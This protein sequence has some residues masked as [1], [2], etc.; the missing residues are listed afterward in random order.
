MQS[1][2]PK[3][4]TVGAYTPRD[5]PE[6]VSLINTIRTD[7]LSLEQ[8]GE[9]EALVGRP[10][11][12][13]RLVC[14]TGGGIIAIGQLNSSPYV[15]DCFA[16]LD[17]VVSEKERCRGIGSGLLDILEREARRQELSGLY[18]EDAE[19]H[20]ETVQWLLRRG[21]EIFRRRRE[22]RLLLD[23]DTSSALIVP[24]TPATVRTLSF[25][26]SQLGSKQFLQF[27]EARL[28]ETPDLEG[29]P[30][31]SS[32][33]L[34]AIFLN[35][36]AAP[37]DWIVLAMVADQ[38]V[39]VGVMHEQGAEAYIYFVG[40]ED[41]VRASSVGTAIL[42]ALVIRA[43]RRGCKAVNI[44]NMESN[45]AALRLTEKLGFMPIRKRIEFRKSL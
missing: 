12:L 15:P 7:P 13:A 26:D 29:L 21:F 18:C 33:Q 34:H 3:G 16:R 39:G 41:Q 37:K 23:T 6:W 28:Q 4:V 40:V 36:P 31:W 22:S 42:S 27:I 10:K 38:P 20:L 11:P 35:N 14:R 19:H 17:M 32:E 44:D 45:I 24:R 1:K 9:R 43:K 8:F 30:A 5:A 2:N 25:P